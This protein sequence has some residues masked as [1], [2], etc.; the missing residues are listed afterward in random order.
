MPR[1][2]V[3]LIALVALA[4]G[5]MLVL[6][7]D[8]GDGPGGTAGTGRA[9][10]AVA[11]GG[12][13]HVADPRD[14]GLRAGWA[15]DPPAMRP[16][17]VPGAAERRVVGG[18]AGFRSFAGSVGWWR[19]TL[20]VPRAGRVAV[21]FGSVGYRATVWIAG[22]EA[23]EH[24]GAYEPFDCVADLPA[25]RHPVMLR[26]DWENPEGQARAGHDRAWWNWGGPNWEVTAREVAPVE[27]QL[28]A[29][30]TRVR[31]DGSARAT[32]TVR[33]RA[34][35]AGPPTGPRTTVRG[36]LGDTPV[37]FPAVALAAGGT[38]RT[39]AR[40]DLPTPALW[41]PG[42]PRLQTLRLRADTAG[43][44]APGLERRVGLRDLR[45][46][47]DGRLRLNGRPFRML[48]VGLPPDARGHGD[49]LTPRDRR[50]ILREIRA[51]GANTVR[52]QHPLSDAML[53]MLDEAGIL[54]WQLVGPFDK[55]GRFWAQTPQ[56]A[57]RARAR[58]LRDVDRMA[59]HSSIAAWSLTNELAGQGHPD[60]QAG[61]L[62]RMAGILQ[63][64]TPGVLVATDVW[65]THLPRERGPA[66]AR[67]DAVGFTEYVGIAE[68]PQEP[69][70]VQ[71]AEVVRRV[72]QLRRLFPSKA[73]VV[74]EFGANGNAQNPTAQPGG[75]AYQA[76]LL[77]RRIALYAARPDVAGMLVW[78]L[79]DYAVSPGFAGG[80][81]GRRQPQLRL[82][83]PLSEKGLFRFDGTAKE[84]VGAV[85][86]AFARVPRGG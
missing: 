17:A 64:R 49:A 18:R 35:G 78:T 76:A 15:T 8:D 26:A 2:A 7:R 23:C 60:G 13:E 84:A 48:G 81:L 68:L 58:I 31:R 28:V 56:R 50:E 55:A 71:D 51:T 67:L 80:S 42:R 52:S 20:T 53:T 38:A 44:D 61:F 86:Q 1:L 14:V 85:R 9:T 21:R 59:A 19:T 16:V 43:A 37:T 72:E 33:L 45:V 6:G 5:A 74:T 39:S 3:L 22:R 12:W 30:T 57:R 75:F 69:V 4:A 32:L 47:R 29:L 54:V 34:R 65:G 10:P 79:R 83:G 24:V 11:L 63:R 73:I 40:V 25:G 62:E 27:L 36:T 82:S 46:T 70:A 66:Y 41:A 77:R